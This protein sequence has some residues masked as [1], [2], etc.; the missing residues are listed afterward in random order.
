MN[1]IDIINSHILDEKS[2][3]IELEHKLES[4]FLKR[5]NKKWKFDIQDVSCSSKDEIWIGCFTNE[6]TWCEITFTHEV[7]TIKT[8][9]DF[10]KTIVERFENTSF[11]STSS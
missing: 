4:E 10:Y 5:S 11:K 8:I 7:S 1:K 6:D 9:S 2:N 3:L